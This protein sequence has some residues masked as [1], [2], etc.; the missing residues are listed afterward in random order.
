MSFATD[1]HKGGKIT[2]PLGVPLYTNFCI[3]RNLSDEEIK[4]NILRTLRTSDRFQSGK[5][6][7]KNI[8]NWGLRKYL[9][10]PIQ[11]VIFDSSVKITTQYLKE[12]TLVNLLTE[13]EGSD[14]IVLKKIAENVIYNPS[15]KNDNFSNSMESTSTSS[16][17]SSS[18]STNSTLRKR[19]LNSSVT[20]R[21]SEEPCPSTSSGTIDD[22]DVSVEDYQ[23]LS[24]RRKTGPLRILEELIPRTPS[25]NGIHNPFRIPSPKKIDPNSK[26]VK[27]KLQRIDLST[28]LAALK[29][30]GVIIK[31]RQNLTAGQLKGEIL[32]KKRKLDEKDII[33]TADKK[34]IK[35]KRGRKNKNETE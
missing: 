23:S 3:I 9:P 6:I 24:S 31:K 35:R 11:I 1:N 22:D 5:E 20:S 15:D 4:D 16:A 33:V 12:N 17:A 14:K 27:S 10:P 25:F 2:P 29:K 8:S 13:E 7:K 28:K 19:K 34:V 21:S 18:T 30:S 26:A 32:I